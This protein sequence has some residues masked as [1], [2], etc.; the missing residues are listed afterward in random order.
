MTQPSSEPG[1]WISASQI[2]AYAYCAESW[3]LAHGLGLQSRHALRLEQG[4]AEHTAWQ[5]VTRTSPREAGHR[6][7]VDCITGPAATSL[8]GRVRRRCA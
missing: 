7:D 5:G 8:A 6:A 1:E 2:A 3:R 4:I